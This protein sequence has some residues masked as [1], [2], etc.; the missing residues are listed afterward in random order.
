[1]NSSRFFASRELAARIERADRDRIIAGA[2]TA[3]LRH[4]D[5]P[6]FAMPI[7]EGAAVGAPI[8]PS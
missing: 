2:E 1:M 7:A 3:R 6:A 5:Q 4:P 8:A